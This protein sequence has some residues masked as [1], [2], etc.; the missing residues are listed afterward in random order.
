[1]ENLLNFFEVFILRDILAFIL[2]GSISLGGIYMILYAYD[3]ERF[4]KIPPFLS[5]LDLFAQIILFLMFL[6]LSFLIGHVWDTRYRTKY[7]IDDDYQRIDIVEKMLTGKATPKPNLANNHKDTRI[8]SLVKKFPRFNSEKGLKESHT[9]ESESVSKHIAIQI[10]ESVG[11]FLNIDWGE[12]PIKTVK[13]WIAAKTK[14]H[15]LSILLSYWIEEENPKIYNDEVARPHI[16]SHFLYVC[17]MAIQFFGFCVSLGVFF[18]LIGWI[19][20]WAHTDILRRPFLDWFCADVAQEP[21]QTLIESSFPLL[22]LVLVTLWF[23]NELIEQGKHKRK[24]LVEHVFR[25]FYV[26]WRKRDLK[27]DANLEKAGYKKISNGK[28]R[29]KKVET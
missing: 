8:Y 19:F 4:G 10:R 29:S 28:N 5:D 17:G 6:M 3:G 12:E 7:Q 14:A 9:H 27:H 18:H 15:E 1:M 22:I 13:K 26:I 24:I 2:P 20:N 11:E 21:F 16:Q 25:T 23:G